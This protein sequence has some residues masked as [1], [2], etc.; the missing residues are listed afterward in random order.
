MAQINGRMLL[1]LKTFYLIKFDHVIV[2]EK[3]LKNFDEIL[4][5]AVKSVVFASC[6]GQ[7]S[8]FKHFSWCFL[9]F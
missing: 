3:I 9:E 2:L 7:K 4:F 5:W 6:D 1:V 8:S